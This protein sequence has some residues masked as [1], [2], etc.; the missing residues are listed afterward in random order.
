MNEIFC[1]S[2][3]AKMSEGEEICPKCQTPQRAKKNDEKT[4]VNKPVVVTAVERAF[5]RSCGE[6][7]KK[8]AEICPKCGVRQFGSGASAK[9]PLGPDE[10]EKSRLIAGL[11]W[12][13]IGGLGIHRFYVGKVGTGI[14]Q[15]CF[16]WAT[17]YIWNLVDGIMILCGAFKDENG[18]K[19]TRWDM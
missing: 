14:L 9:E 17:L 19:L 7:I 18:K 10:S 3:G 1:K 4:A 16:G 5:C 11:L 15:L 2:C 12:F 8:E 13:F 6:S